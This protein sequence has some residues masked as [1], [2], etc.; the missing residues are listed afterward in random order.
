[1]TQNA[2]VDKVLNTILVEDNNEIEKRCILLNKNELAQLILFLTSTKSLKEELAALLGTNQSEIVEAIKTPQV[3]ELTRKQ[4]CKAFYNGQACPDPDGCLSEHPKACDR[5]EC[6]TRRSVDC[7][8]WHTPL[9]K[10]FKRLSH[11]V[12]GDTCTARHPAT[13][14][15]K[16]CSYQSGCAL[17]HTKTPRSR[18]PKVDANSGNSSRRTQARRTDSSRAKSGVKG[19]GTY[20]TRQL[21]E[22]VRMREKIATLEQKQVLFCPQPKDFPPLPSH[23][24]QQVYNSPPAPLHSFPW[25][26]PAPTKGLMPPGSVPDISALIAALLPLQAALQAFLPRSTF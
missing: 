9:C 24:P 15:T 3:T 14:T 18:D 13:C 10:S 25:P 23:Q 26:P 16:D 20:V 11:C 6:K 17:W 4:V 19:K 2:K 7:T 1:M 12:N 22:N 5:P 8:A 21:A